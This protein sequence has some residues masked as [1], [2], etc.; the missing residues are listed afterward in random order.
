MAKLNRLQIEEHLAQVRIAHLVTL[1]P[2]GR[3]HVAPV[4]FDWTESGGQ[5]RAWV[6]AGEKA[7]KISN[8]RRNPGVSLSVATD[9]R[10]YRYVVLEGQARLTKDGLAEVLERI[11]VRYDGPKRG[12]EF[13]RE[14]L[15][16]GDMILL[17]I[18][19]DR[20][21]SWADDE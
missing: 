20:V 6:M 10:P 3:P 14:L 13:A 15:D 2:N 5:G 11:C 17:D 9:E 12:Q 16:R 18:R 21:T 19:V 7:V 4:W 1:R 8:V